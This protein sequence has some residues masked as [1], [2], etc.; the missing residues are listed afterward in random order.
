MWVLQK[1]PFSQDEAPEVL[2][3]ALFFNYINRLVDTYLTRDFTLPSMPWFM[4][5]M[6][7]TPITQ[8]G[9]LSFLRRR[10]VILK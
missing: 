7:K 9:N 10:T 2:G 8:V 6:S 5:L 4:K 3:V 1:P